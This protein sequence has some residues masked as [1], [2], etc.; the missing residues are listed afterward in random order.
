MDYRPALVRAGH[1]RNFRLRAEFNVARIV[2]TNGNDSLVGTS[3][4]DSI[5]GLA[6]NDTL[7]GLGSSDT[8]LGGT[9]DDLYVVSSGDVLSD[10]GGVETVQSAVSWTLGTGFENLTFTG[11]AATSGSGNDLANVMTGNSAGN[12]MRGR[13]GDDTLIGGGGN[14]TFNMRHAFDP[15]FRRAPKRCCAYV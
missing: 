10:S 15:D 5:E 4:A 2:G 7:V 13:G 3:A 6:G 8:L 11:T 12:W 14:D 1:C 9:G